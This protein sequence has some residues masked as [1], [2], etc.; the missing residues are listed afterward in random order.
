MSGEKTEAPTRRRL[1]DRR[2][3]GQVPQRK[4][5]VE[6]A[7]LTFVTLLLVG[8]FGPL[9][10]ALL[11]LSAKA[12]SGINQDFE[13]AKATSFT[14]IVQAAYWIQAICISSAIF[15]LLLGMLLNR[16]VFAPKAFSPK[17]QRFN[18]AGQVKNI[19]SKSTL[20]NFIRMIFLFGTISALFLY[21]YLF[22]LEDSL[23]ASGLTP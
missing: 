13:I 15:T 5:V 2:K 21:L 10:G 9:S 16:F 3:E 18:P 19:F 14:A 7:L 23:E 6:A 8:L 20:Y 22:N 12:F 11:D 4:N 17:F 1:E